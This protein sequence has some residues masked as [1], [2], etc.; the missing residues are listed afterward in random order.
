[1]FK[2]KYKI[3]SS[4]KYP[5]TIY[6]VKIHVVFNIFGQIWLPSNKPRS[7]YCNHNVTIS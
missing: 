4:K 5:A 2:N 1:M 6:T 3:R 7:G